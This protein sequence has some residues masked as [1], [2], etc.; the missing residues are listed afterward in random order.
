[1]AD[2]QGFSFNLG[3]G[4]LPEVDQKKYQD[5]YNECAILRRALRLIA[6]ALDGNVENLEQIIAN[7]KH[8]DLKDIQG[9]SAGEYYHLTSAEYTKVQAM[10]NRKR[11]IKDAIIV[12]TGVNSVTY[13][14]VPPLASV[15]A[16]DLYHLGQSSGA[17]AFSDVEV[18]LSI[19]DVNTIT[20][21]RFGTTGT[22][23]VNFNLV[24]WE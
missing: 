13:A 7:L 6:S 3:I 24:E 8:N 20:A 16:A 22:V 9:G 19:T 14:I 10:T 23:I 2:P 21:D 18:R 5:V 11:S 12:G 1:M 4:V 17:T 15:D